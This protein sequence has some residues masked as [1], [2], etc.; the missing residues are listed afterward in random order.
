MH[1]GR[2]GWY[3]IVLGIDVGALLDQVVAQSLHLGLDREHQDSPPLHTATPCQPVKLHVPEICEE[4]K[5]AILPTVH[6]CDRYR[7]D[8][9]SRR[10]HSTIV[11][12][13]QCVPEDIVKGVGRNVRA[14]D[15]RV[16]CA[17]NMPKPSQ[18]SRVPELCKGIFQWWMAR[19]MESNWWIKTYQLL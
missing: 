7:E 1:D 5:K 16:W 14:V 12:D 11:S 10:N 19:H 18:K 4:G 8:R 9:W 3:A 13:T 15:D 2:E 17:E 6:D